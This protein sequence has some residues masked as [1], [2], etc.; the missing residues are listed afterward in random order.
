M[1]VTMAAGPKRVDPA[2]IERELESLW[3]SLPPAGGS[4]A[5]PMSMRAIVA[6][7]IAL[8]DSER[9]TDEA[10]GVIGNIIGNNPCR[11]ILI[12]SEPDIDPP[13]LMADIAI[14]CQ[15]SETCRR[16]VCC[17]YIRLAGRGIMADNLPSMA[18]TL[19]VSDL[20]VAVW[21]PKPPFD[22]KDFI[23]FAGQANRVIVDSAAYSR[24]DMKQL[25][26]FVEQTRRMGT[27]VS[28]LNWARLTP[29]RQIFAQF[30]DS[31]ECRDHLARIQSVRIE[32]DTSTGLLIAGWLKAQLD[33]SGYPLA[34][35]WIALVPAAGAVVSFQSLAMT[36]AAGKKSFT[37]PRRNESTIEA[38]SVLD[39]QTMNRVVK[40]VLPPE[41]KLLGD[42]L[43][44]SGRDA[45]F[46]TALASAAALED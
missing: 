21:W 37:V 39:A 19:V 41:D 24:D 18:A 46:E 16:C 7:L 6:N 33:K 17:D 30:F 29:Y 5:T 43:T 10:L 9:A 2:A 28:D 13:E 23:V 44:F 4:S 26:R 14:I 12:T 15:K 8:R 42:E 22:R 34:R 40:A 32:A 11:V 38:R 31:P 36:C 27:A 35:E 25:A 20:P 1:S 45:I 3:I